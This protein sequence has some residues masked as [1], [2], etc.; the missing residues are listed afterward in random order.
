MD[1]QIIQ[2]HLQS[3]SSYTVD[4][5]PQNYQIDQ[6]EDNNKGRGYRINIQ[7]HGFYPGPED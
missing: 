4:L 2:L 7:D 1:S 5:V 6:K 3:R